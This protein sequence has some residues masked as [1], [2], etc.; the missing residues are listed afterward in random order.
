[1]T[2]LA[3]YISREFFKLLCICELAFTF[4]YLIVNFSGTVDD[5]IEARVPT[6]RMLL[7][8]LYQTPYIL[9]QMLPPATLIAIIIMFSMMKKNNEIVA[10]K[11]CGLNILKLAQPLFL[12]SLFLMTGLFLFSENVVPYCSTMSNEIWRVEVRKRD[13]SRFLGRSHIWYKGTDAIYWI[14]YFDSKNMVMMD[15]TFYFLDPSFHLT[16]RIDA[17]LAVW[18][19][20]NW[21]VQ[22]GI[23]LEAQE[24]NK[25]YSLKRFQ[26]M[27]LDI[28]ET[29]ETFVREEKNPEEMGYW[30]LRDFAER[31]KAEGYDATRYF[32]DLNIKMSF[33][34]ILPIMVL[35]GT[36]IALGQKKGRTPVAVAIG[37][38]VCFIYLLV[39]G[40]C[41]SI[42]FAGLLPPTLSAWLANGVFFFLGI[43]LI[44][45]VD[46]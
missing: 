10:L 12:L 13:P 31:V 24:H 15:P 23:V 42:G 6:A 21:E 38:V 3:R 33:P 5:F 27:M 37:M 46:R 39:L 9:V 20:G 30:Q 7:F 45:N 25:A 44:M 28:P 1:M 18:K 17:R 34:F 11:A 35:I 36:P 43:Y 16:K 2:I 19:N 22:E 29:P 4:I 26:S 41:R 40:L 8:F 14:R 32:V